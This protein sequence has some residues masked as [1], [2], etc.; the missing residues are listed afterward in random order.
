MG[1]PLDVIRQV[2]RQL[3]DGR[4]EPVLGLHAGA[5]EA[6]VDERRELVGGDLVE[7]HDRSGFVERSL[8]SEH[9]FHERRFGSRED[10]ADVTLMLD[11]RAH[12]VLD[13]SAVELADG[14]KFVERDRDLP[15]ARGG[16]ARRQR[17]DF[18][19]EAGD[20]AFA[21]DA[22][23]RHGHRSRARRLQRRVRRVADLGLRRS[24]RLAQPAARAVPPRFRGDQRSG[25]A[26][27][28]RDVRA[29]AADGDLDGERAASAT[30]PT[31]RGG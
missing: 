23:E 24:H 10:V 8:R 14:L 11:G 16:Q 27:Q 29:E 12:R 17:E 3:D 13:R 2:A 1:E 5:R 28:E 26:L 30:S 22:R 19:R 15:P 25:V 20:L 21:P 4:A 6:G 9:A 7:A 31:A 18:L